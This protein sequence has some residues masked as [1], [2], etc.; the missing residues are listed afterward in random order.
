MSD[1]W[2]GQV[3]VANLAAFF[4]GLRKLGFAIG[5]EEQVLALRSLA[6]VGVSDGK[7]CRDALAA[8]MVRSQQ[9]DRVFAMAWEQFLLGL[10]R[11]DVRGLSDQTLMTHV[12]RLRQQRHRHPQV[13]WLGAT[14]E[15][16]GLEQGADPPVQLRSGASAKEVLRQ[17][18]Y[19]KL[20]PGEQQ[21][22]NFLS[23]KF[24]PLR[25]SSRRR[26]RATRGEWDLSETLRKNGPG[27]DWV[28]VSY[29]KSKVVQRSLLLV[30]DVSGS[31]DPYS[32]LLM[33]FA[34][35]LVRRGLAIQVF[36]FSTRLTSVTRA[37]QFQDPDR[38]LAEAVTRAPDFSGGT[39]LVNALWQLQREYG[40]EVL[41]HAPVVW[42]ASDG[43]DTSRKEDLAKILN[44]LQRQAHWL[45]WLNPA[46][47]D[48]EYSPQAVGAQA[49]QRAA[50]L[51]LPGH[52]WAALVRAWEI[53]ARVSRR[54]PVRHGFDT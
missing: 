13:I 3:L 33:R 10:R 1:P 30:C 53:T 35:S 40:A 49:L 24:I 26:V 32:R 54:R 41:H 45:V 27:R 51:V 16:D 2:D 8:V 6:A 5:A 46:L 52:S 38:A 14:R 42:L 31:M 18:D 22:M 25:K 9:Q 4:N 43:F 23:E 17:A 21:E 36:L 47:G 15:T 48:P 28:E 34:H 19:A 12:A 11:R 29:R 7:Q 44:L 20:T 50:D 39:R 37:L